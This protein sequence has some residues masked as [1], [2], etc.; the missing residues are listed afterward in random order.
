MATVQTTTV[1]DFFERHPL[2]K[3]LVMGLAYGAFATIGTLVLGSADASLPGSFITTAEVA[4]LATVAGA[5]TF[6]VE[7]VS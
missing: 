3:R 6:A 1:T 7:L 2:A 4:P 5:V